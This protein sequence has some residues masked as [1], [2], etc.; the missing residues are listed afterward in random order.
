MNLIIFI[1]SLITVVNVNVNNV[2]GEDQLK[3]EN[4]EIS[5]PEWRLALKNGGSPPEWVQ[6]AVLYCTVLY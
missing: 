1:I 3:K 5:A 2:E 4:K 6:V